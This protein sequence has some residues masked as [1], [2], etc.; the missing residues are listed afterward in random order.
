VDEKTKI[1]YYHQAATTS[2]ATS[3][4]SVPHSDLVLLHGAAF[5]KEDWKK[6]TT[7][8]MQI[9]SLFHQEFPFISVTAVDLPVSADQYQLVA[10]LEAM[11]TSNVIAS[12]PVAGLVTP[13]ASGKTIT[14]WIC[15]NNENE[16]NKDTVLL[17]LTKLS[18][19][20][21]NWIP[22]ASNS[23]KRCTQEQLNNIGALSV[24]SS[25]VVEQQQQ[26]QQQDNNSASSSSSFFEIF[27]IY[28]NLDT[29]G[30]KITEQKL[31][32]Y[33]NAKSLELPGHHPVYLDSPLEFVQAIGTELTTQNQN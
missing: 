12:L 2:E 27:A 23:V 3:G 33:A 8:G 30:K 9:L 5:T 21:H 4:T 10:L 6:P 25:S 26:Q 29:N 15:S 32:P 20:I 13:S 31:V 7:E 17:P 24:S 14:D 19:Y 1:S 18:Q 16:N 22:V 11:L 28:G